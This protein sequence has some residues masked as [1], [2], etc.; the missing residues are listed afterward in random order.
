MPTVLITGANRGLGLEFARQYRRD[1][2]DVIAT[3]CVEPTLGQL[4]DRFRAR[5]A[6][7]TC[8][9]WRPVAR[10]GESIEAL[11]L[12][13]SPTSGDVTVP[14]RAN[15]ARRG[16]RLLDTVREP[17]RSRLTCSLG[18]SL[19]ADE[20]AVAA[21]CIAN[22]ASKM[23]AATTTSAVG[24]LAD[25]ATNAARLGVAL[26]GA[27]SGKTASFEH[28]RSRPLSFEMG[29]HDARCRRRPCA[30]RSPRRRI[31]SAVRSRIASAR[32]DVRGSVTM[33][34]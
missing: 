34:R 15:D 28:Q 12:L 31:A 2:W 26:P 1:G 24:H 16:A 33:R 7:S 23:R 17:I 20:S 4:E 11:D 9:T 6:K 30:G 8:S 14:D 3:A 29:V 19:P 18:L 21:S 10:L 5:R 22:P 13:A 27:N 32:F 25:E